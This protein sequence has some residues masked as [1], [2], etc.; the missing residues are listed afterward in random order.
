MFDSTGKT[1]TLG[2][3]RA[4]YWWQKSAYIPNDE[5]SD[6]L[7]FPYPHRRTHHFGRGP[8]MMRLDWIGLELRICWIRERTSSAPE[9]EL[10]PPKRHYGKE[11]GYDVVSANEVLTEELDRMVMRWLNLMVELGGGDSCVP[12]IPWVSWKTLTKRVRSNFPQGPQSR[13]SAS[14]HTSLDIRKVLLATSGV[15]IAGCIYADHGHGPRAMQSRFAT[16][17]AFPRS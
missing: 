8:H 3:T 6:S 7:Q 17:V 16:E 13:G 15:R 11:R 5:L 1:D 14:M 10:A 9:E 4:M 2:S 12:P